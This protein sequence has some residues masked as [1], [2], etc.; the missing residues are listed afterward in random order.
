MY[1]YKS[2][3]KSTSFLF[4]HRLDIVICSFTFCY[5]YIHTYIWSKQN[6]MVSCKI[7]KKKLLKLV[8]LALRLFTSLLILLTL[9]IEAATGRCSVRKGAPRNF[10]KFTEKHLCQGLFFNKGW[11]TYDVHFKRG[12]RLRQK[13]VIGSR[14]WGVSVCSGRPILFNYTI[15]SFVG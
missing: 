3:K 13:Y 7:L 12:W 15:P 14:A 4:H 1:I 9:L 6:Q 10:A 11:Y 2:I 8:S 5:E